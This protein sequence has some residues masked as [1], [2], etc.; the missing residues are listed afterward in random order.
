MKADSNIFLPAI[1]NIDSIIAI[2]EEH[3]PDG[4]S[5]TLKHKDPFQLL[6]A[7]ILSA[8]STDKLVNTVTPGLFKK[9]GGPEDFASTDPGTL[10]DDIRPT[11]FFR[12]KAKS[13]I[14]ASLEIVKTFGG[15]VPDN[16]DDLLRLPGVGRK[17]ANVVLGNCFGKQVI[18][19]DTHVKRISRLIGLTS[20]TN[21]DKIEYDLAKIVP[22]D[23]QTSFSH[24]IIEHGR[25]ICIAR[26][27]GCRICPILQYCR[28]GQENN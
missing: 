10:E 24:R 8:Q 5:S 22:E 3:Y 28:Y 6:V 23:K 27:P 2:L 18:I 13:I 4:A 15:R 26:R 9:Y 7:T 19:V 20:N 17:T 11:G 12:N 1:K 25:S 14:G 21:P 16:M